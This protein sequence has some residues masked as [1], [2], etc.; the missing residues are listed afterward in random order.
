[1]RYGITF[2]GDVQ[3]LLI[4][5]CISHIGLNDFGNITMSTANVPLYVVKDVRHC[6]GY[7][8]LK[9]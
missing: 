5:L 8:D 3:T 9:K 4:A 7:M 1:M 6:L 2:L